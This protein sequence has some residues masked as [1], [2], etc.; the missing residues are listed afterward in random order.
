MAE[1]I[2]LLPDQNLSDGQQALAIVH[3]DDRKRRELVQRRGEVGKG[4]HSIFRIIRPRDGQIAWLEERA[5]VSQDPTTGKRRIAGLAWDITE[6][7]QAAEHQKILLAE[8]QHRTRN[9]LGVVRSITDRTQKRAGSLQEFG[10]SF[11]DRLEALARVNGLLSRLNERE[12]IT[13]SELIRTELSGLGITEALGDAGQVS[14][15][16][17]ENVRLRSSTVQ[18]LALGLHELATNALKYGALSR[19]EGRLSIRWSLKRPATGDRRL[20]VDWREDGISVQLGPDD[21]PAR[22]G[23]GRELIERALPYQLKAETSYAITREGVR[24]IISLPLS[25][26][27]EGVA[28]A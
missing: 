5:E 1:L 20:Q 17:P 7:K 23:Y 18:T 13:F 14:L 2:G 22:R 27:P 8:L 10:A 24:C 26:I 15:H 4:W 21:E 11:R 28:H 9:L 12:R 16:G 6:Q 25:T 19:P 3:P